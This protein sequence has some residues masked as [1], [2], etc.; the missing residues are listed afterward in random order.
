MR[1]IVTLMTSKYP[2]EVYIM[3]AL[4]FHSL[5]YADDNTPSSITNALEK[6]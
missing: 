3:N 6:H 5:H 2:E 1:Q 4:K